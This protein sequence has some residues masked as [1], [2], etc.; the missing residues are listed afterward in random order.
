VIQEAKQNGRIRIVPWDWLE[1]SLQEKVRKPEKKYQLEKPESRRGKKD[2]SRTLL[3][4]QLDQKS[5]HLIATTWNFYML[6]G[7]SQRVPRRLR[8][9]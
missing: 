3:K 4:S 2:A 8:I 7:L 9:S 1:D 5:K 6:T